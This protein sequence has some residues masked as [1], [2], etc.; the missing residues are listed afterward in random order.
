MI[1]VAVDAD[2]PGV[3]GWVAVRSTRE[4]VVRGLKK[5]LLNIHF[6]CDSPSMWEAR[7]DNRAALPADATR[8]KVE[9][10]ELEDSRVF[11]DLE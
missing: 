5:G 10:V 7:C 9:I 2:R 11:V 4:L 8:V 6:D 3:T 1:A